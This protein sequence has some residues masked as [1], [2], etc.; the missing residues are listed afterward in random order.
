MEN[1]LFDLL[2]FIVR[3][4]KGDGEEE[5]VMVPETWVDLENKYFVFPPEDP[6]SGHPSN[7]SNL[8][9]KR[10]RNPMSQW[11]EIKMDAMLTEIA[12]K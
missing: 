9:F 4:S 11:K 6:I 7:W 8:I 3:H 12:C 2:Y 1:V 10:S 5:I